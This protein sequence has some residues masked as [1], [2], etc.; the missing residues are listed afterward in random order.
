MILADWQ[1]VGLLHAGGL[2]ATAGVG[3]APG[4]TCVHPP[5]PAAPA[6]RTFIVCTH[7]H[8]SRL[9]SSCVCYVLCVVVS[10]VQGQGT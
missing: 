1:G 7:A 5:A 8:S 6:S 4:T 10:A 9:T 3:V 2:V